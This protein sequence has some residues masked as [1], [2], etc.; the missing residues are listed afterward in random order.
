M[1]SNAEHRPTCF[2]TDGGHYENL[3]VEPLLVRRCKLIL[4]MDAG[5]DE[6]YEFSDLTNLIRIAR[7]SHGISFERVDKPD[8]PID[9]GQLTPSI[10]AEEK[11]D[12]QDSSETD[13]GKVIARGIRMSKTSPEGEPLKWS[14][15]QFLVLKIK[16]PATDE[17]DPTEG[18]LI[19]MKSTMTG[20]EPLELRQF[21][22]FEPQFPHNP[23]A[24]QFYDPV[25]F[26]AYVELG[27]HIA[28]QI[29]PLGDP[30]DPRQLCPPGFIDWMA[31]V[32]GSTASEQPQTK[33]QQPSPPPINKPPRK[34]RGKP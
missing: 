33:S 22:K 10:L 20:D 5:Y 26:D 13:I 2:V 7:V 8:E 17:H 34:S 1:F 6:N 14:D 29:G 18:Y 16:Y 12:D 28:N 11:R 9:L 32:H 24:D 3:A 4:A 27:Y 31:G 19:Y 25:R 30:S 15:R 23:T 21:K